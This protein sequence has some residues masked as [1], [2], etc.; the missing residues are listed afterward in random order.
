MSRTTNK[1][2]KD[3]RPEPPVKWAALARR[4]LSLQNNDFLQQAFLEAKKLDEPE[5]TDFFRAFANDNKV[6]ELAERLIP[7]LNR[8]NRREEA[9][10]IK[11]FA[12]HTQ[13]GLAEDYVDCP[14]E[15]QKEKREKGIRSCQEAI[16]VAKTLNNKPCQAFY[17]G[18]LADAYSKSIK[19]RE[20]ELIFIEALRLYRELDLEEPHIYTKNLATVLN[21]LG[22][23]Q[24]QIQKWM[25]AEKS[26][27]KALQ[28]YRKMALEN[29]GIFDRNVTE[30]LN[31]L[32]I[33]QKNLGKL[34]DAEKSFS[35]A[36]QFYRGPAP[37]EPYVSDISMAAILNNLSNVQKRSNRSLDAEK[38]VSEALELYRKLDLEKPRVFIRYIAGTLKNLGSLQR[39]L[40]NLPRAEKSFAEA[41]RLYRELAVQDA[42]IFDRQV[43]ST[44]NG[45]GIVHTIMENLPD[46]ETV[47]TEALCLYRDL[48]L[49]EPD[50]FDE[51]IALALDGLG[52]VQSRMQKPIDAEKSFSEA[53]QLYRKMVLQKPDNFGRNFAETLNNLGYLQFR[54]KRFNE[55]IE[56]FETARE[57]IDNLRS[58]AITL[59]ERSSI[60][61]KSVNVYNN[62]LACYIKINNREKALEIAEWGKSRSLSDLLNLKSVDLQPKAPTPGSLITVKNLG[63]KYSDAIK[64]L[65]QFESYEKYLSEQLSPL[66]KAIK[67]IK[68]E[69]EIDDDTR[70][71]YLLQVEERKQSLDQEKRKVQNQRFAAQATLKSVLAKI[72]RYD[73]HF[74]LKAKDIKVKNIF[75]ISKNLN[76]TIV[77]FRLLPYSTAIIF[78]FPSGEIKIKEIKGFGQ[79]EMYNLFVYKWAVPYRQWKRRPTM[80]SLKEA[81]F[82][83][84]QSPETEIG[85]W[86]HLIEKTL[87]TLYK[88]L[89]IHVRRILKKKS[90]TKNILFIPSQSLAVLPL[91]A[92]SWKKKNGKTRYLLEEFTISYCPSVSVFKR[93][94]ENEK[95]RTDRSLLIT[96]PT[97]DL[98]FSEKETEFIESFHQPSKKIPGRKATKS[99]VIKALRDDY[100]FTHFA[101]HGFYNPE[102][103]FNSG[104][105][106]AD[107]VFKLSEIINCNFQNNWLTTLSACE[108]GMVD[109]DSPTDEHFGLPLGFIFAGSPSVWASL[110]SVNDETTSLLMQKAY[111]NLSNGKFYNNKSEALRQAQLSILKKFSHPYHWAGFQHYGI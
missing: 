74:P 91:H 15:E 25:D 94:V 7:K 36:L 42:D 64:K 77:I 70:Q 58:K 68:D 38:S 97:R 95:K 78:V 52:I 48:A 65:Q 79:G 11:L 111:K 27:I 109:F 33:G 29:P 105:V 17:S 49:R 88:K 10:T 8:A 80:P 81:S 76:R 6:D 62:L 106:M 35:E 19:L 69:T 63:R 71:A 32:G 54:Q 1:P 110:W 31:N 45:L 41:L 47:F 20:A 66:E 100:S 43:A 73:P 14:F 53:V 28:L 39:N 67:R 107:Q 59:D 101:C 96:N 56:N 85:N 12:L 18:I 75:E 61:Q 21:N 5:I 98:N 103:Q 44:L 37:R 89:M 99:A 93:C 24:S 3:N 50:I 90:P 84:V 92:A 82:Q 26:F 9:L 104:L 51:G 83:A 2:D 4:Y 57:V 22:I 23:A 72:Y 87:K 16:E 60:L 13:V 30:I 46:A 40:E 108:T 34:T 102:N 55:A 86:F